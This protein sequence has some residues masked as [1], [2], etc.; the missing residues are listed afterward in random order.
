LTAAGVEL[1]TTYS[2]VDG[3]EVDD[4]A[5]LVSLSV[6]QDQDHPS[7]WL[8][9]G[10]YSTNRPDPD[11]LAGPLERRPKFTWSFERYE[12]ALQMDLDGYPLWNTVGD[13]F[14]PP[15]ARDANR[16]MLS[17]VK[18]VAAFDFEQA[19]EYIDSVNDRP[20][21][22]FPKNCAKI[23]GISC[24]D[25]MFEDDTEFYQVTYT[26][27]FKKEHQQI[28]PATG[29]PAEEAGQPL[30]SGWQ[31][32]LLNQG[33]R[34]LNL[35]ATAIL[36]AEDRPGTPAAKPILLTWEGNKFD[37]LE[38]TP[39]AVFLPFR[40]YEAKDWTILEIDPDV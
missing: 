8:A 4:G 10:K 37:D 3:T 2:N 6:K 15:P 9:V 33:F 16:L 7:A 1:D 24:S 22:G 11:R 17:V 36:R 19:Q 38:F 26:I 21:V 29:E 5:Y 13:P 23:M 40:V 20:F 39:D 32:E 18:N 25:R 34:Y 30:Y 28:D 27:A 14:D 35:A 31:F 12:K